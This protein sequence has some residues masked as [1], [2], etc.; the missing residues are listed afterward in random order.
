MNEKRLCSSRLI[1]NSLAKLTKILIKNMQCKR[2]CF[3]SEGVQA[4]LRFLVSI[5]NLGQYEKLP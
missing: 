2:F 5:N 3:I 4:V 1:F